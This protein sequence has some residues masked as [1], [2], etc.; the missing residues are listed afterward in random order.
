MELLVERA[1]PAK[2]RSEDSIAA[3]LDDVSKIC[4]C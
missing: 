3:L 1:G 2:R 4:D